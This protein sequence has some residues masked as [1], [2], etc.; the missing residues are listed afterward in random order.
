MDPAG[1]EKLFDSTVTEGETKI[2]PD[3]VRDDHGGIT[4]ALVQRRIR[5]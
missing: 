1:G 3:S 4:V 5:G 2:E